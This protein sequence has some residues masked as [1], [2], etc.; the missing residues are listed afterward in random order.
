MATG[1]TAK[2]RTSRN[3]NPPCQNHRRRKC[4]FPEVTKVA[5]LDRFNEPRFGGVGI[6]ALV[7]AYR[8]LALKTPTV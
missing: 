1:N 8:C 6:A 3:I 7:L 5:F 4:K 2:L